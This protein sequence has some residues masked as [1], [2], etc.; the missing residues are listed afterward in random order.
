MRVRI[1]ACL[2]A[3][4]LTGLVQAQ[5]VA[6]PATSEP[7]KRWCD[8]YFAETVGKDV[9][10]V[11]QDGHYLPDVREV[12]LLVKVGASQPTARLISWRGMYRPS[13][14]K[15]T[16]GA[17]WAVRQIKVVSR[18]EFQQLIDKQEAPAVSR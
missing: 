6:T 4:G 13:T 12:Y 10:V 18:A 15:P 2:L 11:D 17:S 7:A 8:L 3:L 1:F 14:I 16:D 5:E 9:V